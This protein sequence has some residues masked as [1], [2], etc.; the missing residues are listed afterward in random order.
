MGKAQIRVFRQEYTAF[1]TKELNRL[2][3]RM[4]GDIVDMERQMAG[5]G[6]EQLSSALTC[7]HSD[8]GALL[9]ERAQGAIV[10]AHYAFLKDIDT[11][12]TVSAYADDVTVLI[13]DQGDVQALEGCLHIFERV[14]SAKVNWEKTEALLDGLWR[15]R[16]PWECPL[17]SAR[18][19]G[20][21][22]SSWCR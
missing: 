19:E 22:G 15:G 4:E 1:T 21:R 5:G 11:A 7:L 12:I 20:L 14:A 3:G 10:R 18:D 17:G 6:D 2:V 13:Q 9:R 16:T 8:L